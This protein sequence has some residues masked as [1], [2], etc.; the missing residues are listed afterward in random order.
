MRPFDT[1]ETARI[2]GF[3]AEAGIAVEQDDLPG[4]TFL[5]GMTV[6]RGVLVVDPERL[7]FPGDMLH[8]AGHIAVADPGADH[9]AVSPD[10]GEEMAAIAWSYAAACAIPLDPRIV[11][12][13]H[14]YRGDGANIA[15]NFAQGRS[16]G[17][18][19]LQYWGLTRTALYPQMRHWRR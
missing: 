7:A 17:V 9:D 12:H 8:E 16:F 19:L 13:D 5:P 18:P 11:F 1:P 14:G 4:E 10:P 15:E 2:L 6:R 3:L